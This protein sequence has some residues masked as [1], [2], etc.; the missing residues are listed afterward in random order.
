MSGYSPNFQFTLGSSYITA[1]PPGG[2]P[3]SGK[4][5]LNVDSI[6]IWGAA[7]T[8]CSTSNDLFWTETTILNPGNSAPVVLSPF[9]NS[10]AQVVSASSYDQLLW[11]PTEFVQP[12][13]SSS[14]V[15]V[16]NTALGF[17]NGTGFEARVV[18]GFEIFGSATLVYDIAVPE[19]S[20]GVLLGVGLV[21]LAVRRRRSNRAT[22]AG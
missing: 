16:L 12:G 17:N 7:H 2:V 4:L 10:G 6:R 9:I 20:T 21:G 11:D 3:G 15:F 14:R 1:L 13:L 18:E 8:C 22:S 5:R 19:P